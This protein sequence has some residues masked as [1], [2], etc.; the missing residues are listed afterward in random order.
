MQKRRKSKK[1]KKNKP[2]QKG[3]LF[4]LCGLQLKESTQLVSFYAK[5][6]PKNTII[7]IKQKWSKSYLLIFFLFASVTS[8]PFDKHP[9]ST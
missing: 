4:T 8:S 1:E 9:T 3:L 6:L 7:Y 5:K 2:Y